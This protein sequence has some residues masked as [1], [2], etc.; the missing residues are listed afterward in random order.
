M[1]ED[2]IDQNRYQFWMQGANII[3]ARLDKKDYFTLRQLGKG[4]P[5]SAF[6]IVPGAFPKL[7]R[8]VRQA[9]PLACFDW[10]IYSLCTLAFQELF[11][12]ESDSG[13]LFR[14]YR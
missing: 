2:G 10:D 8:V 1:A 13:R 7:L 6:Q 11:R 9:S 14:I 5:V 3:H 12:V 4:P